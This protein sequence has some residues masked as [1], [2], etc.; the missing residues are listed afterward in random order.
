MNDLFCEHTSALCE[1]ET[2]T[3]AAELFRQSLEEELTTGDVAERVDVG[4][5]QVRLV[6]NE[7]SADAVSSPSKRTLSWWEPTTAS[8]TA[9]MVHGSTIRTCSQSVP[10]SETVVQA[11]ADWTTPISSAKKNRD[12]CRLLKTVPTMTP[13]RTSLTGDVPPWRRR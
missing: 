11:I 6:L 12:V 8:P 3:A 10:V 7:P 4:A 1:S 9:T 13:A 5:R 2:A